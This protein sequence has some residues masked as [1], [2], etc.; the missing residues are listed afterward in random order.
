MIDLFALVAVTALASDG[1]TDHST[2]SF[3][4]AETRLRDVEI[5]RSEPSGRAERGAFPDGTVVTLSADYCTD[6]AFDLTMDAP[7]DAQN[8]MRLRQVFGQFD[9]FIDCPIADYDQYDVT[10][11]AVDAALS[12]GSAYDNDGAAIDTAGANSIYLSIAPAGD[13]IAATIRCER[14]PD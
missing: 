14:Q 7:S 12:A 6:P 4:L 10:L 5:V 13:R 8:I 11:D 1:C 2:Y 3:K 9:R